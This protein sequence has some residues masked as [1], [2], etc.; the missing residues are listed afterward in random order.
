MREVLR[1]AERFA[2]L[3]LLVAAVSIAAVPKTALAAAGNPSY[4]DADVP[5][6]TNQNIGTEVPV[7]LVHGMG[8]Y[9]ANANAWGSVGNPSSF[10]GTVDRVPG[11]AVAHIFHYDTS[12]W[13]DQVSGPQLAKTIDCVSR[14]SI[15][16]GGK[17]KVILVGYSMGGLVAREALSKQ[18]TDGQRSIASE[19][20]QVITIGSPHVGAE[21]WTWSVFNAGSPELTRLP[22]F[23]SSTTVHTIA[24]NVTK[25]TTDFWNAQ[26]STREELNT[27]TLVSTLSAHSEYTIDFNKGGG[28]KTISCDKYYVKLFGVSYDTGPASC[29]HDQL[30]SNPLNGVRTDTTDAIKK[31]VTWLNTPPAPETFTAGTITVSFDDRW[32]NFGYGASGPDGDIIGQDTQYTSVLITNM[33]QWCTTTV[34]ECIAQND[35][36]QLG[37]APDITVGGRTPDY[38]IRYVQ[39]GHTNGSRLIWC[40]ETEK[41][42]IDYAAGADVYLEPSDA[43]LD[44]LHAATWS[45]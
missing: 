41:V 31:Y 30:I 35:W 13:V 20:G 45:N 17:G 15:Q 3:L 40:F 9:N 44:L 23:P 37:P 6:L 34:Q 21:V 42:C 43:L 19:V 1:R 14:L 26:S 11:V 10:A 39:P 27:D 8:N 36:Q 2:V 4:C 7:I 28:Q 29:Q 12:V 24:G 25:V 5:K 33:A 38:S 18:S 22:H 16:K 32:Q